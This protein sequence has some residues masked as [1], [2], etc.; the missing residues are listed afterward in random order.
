MTVTDGLAAGAA[1]G[2]AGRATDRTLRLALIPPLLIRPP[3][4]LPPKHKFITP[5]CALRSDQVK[6]DPT[7][8]YAASASPGNAKGLVTSRPKRPVRTALRSK[9]ADLDS[10]LTDILIEFTEHCLVLATLRSLMQWREPALN[11]CAV[12]NIARTATITSLDI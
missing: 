7:I 9:G 1:T 3:L 10:S 2:A 11:A 4:R 8:T 6:I 5:N 12:A